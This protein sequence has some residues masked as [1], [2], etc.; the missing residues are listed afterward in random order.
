MFN[1]L[2]SLQKRC[3]AMA[4][5][6]EVCLLMYHVTSPLD[7]PHL[8]TP[9]DQRHVTK[10]DD[11]GPSNQVNLVKQVDSC[12]G[13]AYIKLG[14]DDLEA[15]AVG[16]TLAVLSLALTWAGNNGQLGVL[17]ALQAVQD[18]GADAGCEYR[19]ITQRSLDE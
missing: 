6:Q 18:D 7:P 9:P 16:S 11:K 3:L 12:E 19:H 2:Q 10:T 15:A 13:A 17:G 14:I 4:T 1:N 8:S 5:Q